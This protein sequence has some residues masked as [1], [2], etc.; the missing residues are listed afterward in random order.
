MLPCPK[1]SPALAPPPVAAWSVP[2]EHLPRP[3]RDELRHLDR[4]DCAVLFDGYLRMLARQ[5]A[6]CRRVL[7]RI[8]AVFLHRRGHH[9]LSFTRLGDYTRER[10]GLSARELQSVARVAAKLDELPVLAHAFETGTLSW[11]QARLLIDVATPASEAAWI[12]VAR[13]LTVRA[14][15]RRIRAG[16]APAQ[17]G[18]APAP[19]PAAVEPAPGDPTCPQAPALA[20]DDHAQAATTSEGADDAST[21]DGEPAVRIRLACPRRVRALW[22]ATVELARRVAG[23]PLPV[24]EACEAIAAEALSSPAAAG[25]PAPSAPPLATP[26]QIA[27]VDVAREGAERRAEAFPYVE[28]AAITAVI[29]EPVV[30]LAE[31]LDALDAFALDARL[32]ATLAAMHRVHWQTGRLLRLVLDLRLYRWLGFPTAERY[33]QERLGM[34]IRTAQGLVVVERV[35]WRAPQL[36]AAYERGAIAPLR[37]LVIAPVLSERHEAAWLARANAVTIRRLGDEVTWALNHQDVT[38]LCEPVAPPPAGALVMP[39]EAQMRA[40]FTDETPEVV[41]SV[42]APASVAALFETAIAAFTSAGEPRWRGFERLLADVRAE[43]NARPLHRDPIFA[44]EGWRCAVP[45]CSARKNLHDH[46]IVFRSRAGGNTRDNRVAICAAHHQHGVHGGG[47]VRAWG[48]APDD[49]HWELGVRRDGP[50]LLTLIGDRYVN[51]SYS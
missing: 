36:A 8:A 38:P 27:A 16:G 39:S 31:G 9:R 3:A 17:A 5:D 35:T 51:E 2:P 48:E 25:Q 15:A 47:Y 1:R 49:I 6:S 4:D 21:I 26:H 40:R 13:E 46:H 12:D 20:E 18:V 7:G 30:A 19:A 50:P 43:W 42:V 14:L 28:W 41:I 11:T 10:L 34:G 29:P 32:R 23:E 24:W 33:V 44:R 45:A 37:A 22:R